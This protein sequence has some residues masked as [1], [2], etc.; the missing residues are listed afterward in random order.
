MGL[1]PV[2]LPTK[3]YL[4]AYIQSK[5]GEK[6]VM[7]STHHIGSKLIDLLS[8]SENY[9]ATRYQSAAYPVKMRV[10]IT[11]DAFHNKGGFLNETNI[12]SFNNYVQSYF[13]EYTRDLLDIYLELTQSI[14]V[15]IELMRDRVGLDENVFPYDLVKK[16][17]YRYRKKKGI[18]LPNGGLKKLAS[19]KIDCI[20]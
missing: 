17:Y 1:I 10:Y 6:P 12:I 8:R 20:I 18:L 7:T 9:R 5:L 4:K 2:D 11:K 15:S 3:H 14:E 16:D 13:K 19:T